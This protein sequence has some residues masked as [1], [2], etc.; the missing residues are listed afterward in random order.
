MTH[1]LILGKPAL[2]LAPMEGVGDATMREFLTRPGTD[3]KNPYDFCF[4]EFQR[5]SVTPLSR[6]TL[7]RKIPEVGFETRSGT[8]LLVQLLGGHPGRLA[9]TAR[10]AIEA[11]A[12][13]IDLNFGCPA[14]TVNRN[15]GGATLLKYPDRIFEIVQ[16]VRA[17]V[18]E[19]HSVSAKLRLGWDSHDPIHKNAEMAVRA[20]ASWITIHARTRMQ[21]YQPPVYWQKI[22]EVRREV[23]STVP[24]VANGDI[25]SLDDFK[26]CR[27]L[28]GAEHFML[29]RGALVEPKLATQIKVELTGQGRAIPDFETWPR[30]FGDFALLAR[31]RGHLADGQ[32]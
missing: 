10:A 17:T 11:G 20:G 22:A 4:T 28:T 1:G 9:E 7:V 25:W 15:D 32:I 21:A 13:G 26:R 29:G 6:R 19:S 16:A 5:V 27:D 30:L 3:G 31:E 12:P 24:V 23:G 2:L 18:P 8:P 14:P